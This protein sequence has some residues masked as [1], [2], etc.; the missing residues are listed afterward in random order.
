MKIQLVIPTM[1]SFLIPFRTWMEVSG[2]EW[3]IGLALFY[4]IVT[5]VFNIPK[6]SRAF[7]KRFLNESN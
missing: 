3:V 2:Q 7:K 1:A 5:I 4:W 6:W